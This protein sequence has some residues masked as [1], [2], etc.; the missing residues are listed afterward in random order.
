MSPF[1]A[2]AD[3]RFFLLSL[4]DRRRVEGMIFVAEGVRT[5]GLLPGYVLPRP[6]FSPRVSP[7][8][9]PLPDHSSSGSSPSGCSSIKAISRLLI[10]SPNKSV[11]GHA[12]PNDNIDSSDLDLSWRGCG[13]GGGSATDGRGSSGC[14][15]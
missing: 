6:P 14:E 4:R 1:I 5:R 11:N 13:I 10:K 2:G 8:D 3:N 12:S 7:G 9:P 15:G